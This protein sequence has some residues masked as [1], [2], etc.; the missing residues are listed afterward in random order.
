MDKNLNVEKKK[1]S[2]RKT[3]KDS[4]YKEE[5]AKMEY[6]GGLPGGYAPRKEP[7]PWLDNILEWL[8]VIFKGKEKN[9]SN[10]DSGNKH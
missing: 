4:D 6:E 8:F 10:K 5:I 7:M 9:K 1:A 2:R 3:P